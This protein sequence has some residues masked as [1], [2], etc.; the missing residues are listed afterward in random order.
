MDNNK[1]TA[2]SFFQTWGMQIKGF[3]I[4]AVGVLLLLHTLGIIE[5]GIS[6]IL[7]LIASA[8]IV[9]G[10]LMTGYYKKLFKD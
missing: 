4:M 9:Y 5:R 1:K 10:F 3:A 8:L 7:I 2:Y 6:A